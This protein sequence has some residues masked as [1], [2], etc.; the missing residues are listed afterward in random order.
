MRALAERLARTGAGAARG[1]VVEGR[2]RDVVGLVLEAGGCRAAVGDAVE[3]RP[4]GRAPLRAEVVGLKDDRLLCMPLGPVA[5]LDAGTPLRP[6]GGAATVPV[7]DALVGRVVD[8]LGRPLD[9]R[10]APV[11]DRRRPLDGAPAHPLA[12]RAV[13]A[14]FPVGV[15]A[16]DGLLTLGEGQRIGIFAGGG[17]GKSTLLAMMVRRAAADVC[18]VGLVGERGREVEELVHE[19]LGAEGLARSVVVAATSAEP[20]LLRARA[21]LYATTVAE[22]FR[23]QGK[24]VLLVMDSVTRFAIALREIG[25]AVGEPPATKGYPPSVFAALPRLLERAGTGEGAG[26]ITA[27][28]TVLVEGDDLADPISDA[29]R[30]ILDGHFVLRRELAERGHFPALDV[31]ASVSRV[32]PRVATTAQRELAARARELLAAERE[33]DDLRAIGAYTPGSLPRLDEAAERAPGL[34]QFLRQGV[35]DPALDLGGTVAALAGVFGG[36]A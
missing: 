17:V 9:G 27:V 33:L 12:R 23:D 6:L 36:A 22:H 25:L 31:A 3:L 13:D 30:A 34:T 1:P 26:A 14:P 35:G 28:Y 8:A 4:A 5:G 16:I 29:A 10:P 15:R 11:L 32:F 2:L 20:P 18:V 21:A 24:R 7:G 19:T